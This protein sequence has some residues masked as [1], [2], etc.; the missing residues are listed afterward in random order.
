MKAVV[1]EGGKGIYMETRPREG[2]RRRGS[3]HRRGCG[4]SMNKSKTSGRH[5]RTRGWERLGRRA[6]SG[7][8]DA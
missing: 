4:G 2:G 1:C 6:G 5:K 7:A 3:F 8:R